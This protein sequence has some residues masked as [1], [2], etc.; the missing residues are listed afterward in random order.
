[1]QSKQSFYSV[2]FPNIASCLRYLDNKNEDVTLNMHKPALEYSKGTISIDLVKEALL[3]AKR[4]EFDISTI[5]KK[6]NIPA[7]VLNAPQARGRPRKRLCSLRCKPHISN[8]HIPAHKSCCS[9]FS[10]PGLS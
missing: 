4:L 5:L 10:S 6:A 3:D 8:R 9:S 1:M 2:Q 7:E